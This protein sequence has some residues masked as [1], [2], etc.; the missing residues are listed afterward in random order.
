ME[1]QEALAQIS[2]IR[3]QMARSEV[4]RGFRAIPV[5]GSGCLAVIAAI[6][7]AIW[8]PEPLSHPQHYLSLWVGVAA[9][10]LAGQILEMWWRSRTSLSAYSKSITLLAAE[11][12]FPSVIAGGLLTFV[13]TRFAPE[14]IWMLP[15]LWQVLLG[16]G[17]FATY[18]LLP[19]A[20]FGV[21]AFYVVSGIL[22]LALARGPLALSPLA[23]GIP[24]GI[25]QLSTAA[26]LYWTLERN[27]EE[28]HKIR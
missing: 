10:S 16:L 4:F 23:M 13:L 18:R 6:V 12:F 20:M 7:Q 15:G 2:E 1:L 28:T 14:V 27:D 11:Q 25:G 22:C 8:L 9:I 21:A 19:K 5:A 24:F 17:I 3:Q 26:I